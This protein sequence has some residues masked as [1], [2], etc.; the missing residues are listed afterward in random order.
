MEILGKKSYVSKSQFM[1]HIGVAVALRPLYGDD[2]SWMI[3][4]KIKKRNMRFK[5][6]LLIKASLYHTSIGEKLIIKNMRV[7]YNGVGTY[8]TDNTYNVFEFVKLMKSVMKSRNLS[9]D[10]NKF[11]LTELNQLV[12]L[13]GDNT[14]SYISFSSFT[15]P[16]ISH[17]FPPP[18]KYLGFS[19]GK[20]FTVSFKILNIS[21]CFSPT[22]NPPIA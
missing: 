7:M 14:Q 1:S 17:F 13:S 9:I 12:R 4:D 2:L 15:A 16:T 5:Y 6:E 21:D 19:F 8:K 20:Y 11:S 10:E 22:A 18:I 3:E